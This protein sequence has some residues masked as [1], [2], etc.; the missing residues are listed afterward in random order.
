MNVVKNIDWSPSNYLESNVIAREVGREMLSRL[1][2]MTIKPRVVLD[3]GCA[4]GE[5]SRL[6]QTRYPDATILPWDCAQTMLEY[7]KKEN[8]SPF[9]VCTDAQKLPLKSQ[10]V[11]LIFANLILPWQSSFKAF[12][13]ECQRVLI[14]DGVLMLSALGIDTLKEWSNILAPQHLPTV[15][16][17]HDLGDLLLREKFADPVL[18]VDY[19]TTS[20]NDLNKL[21]HELRASG[22]WF[23]D[24]A[25]EQ[26]TQFAAVPALENQWDVTYEIIYAHA[27]ATILSEQNATNGEVNIPLNQLRDMLKRR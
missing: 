20:Y 10:S 22:M 24:P 16:D 27:F 9:Y 6:L 17:M 8:A 18:D 13:R 4:T 23:P 25:T 19:Y 11:D 3:I 2:W 26:T 7:A 12:L 5:S 14:K 21:T 15:I 1:D